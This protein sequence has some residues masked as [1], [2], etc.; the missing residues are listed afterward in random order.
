MRTC[1]VP[2]RSSPR[3][4]GAGLGPRF[5]RGRGD[6]GGG[7]TSDN[8]SAIAA[9]LTIIAA[10][11]QAQLSAIFSVRVPDG[12]AQDDNWRHYGGEVLLLLR[13]AGGALGGGGGGAGEQRRLGG[14]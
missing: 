9:E 4:G 14:R 8:G 11:A 12:I 3:T 6:N 5:A 10:R 7:S 13:H 2:N 1:F